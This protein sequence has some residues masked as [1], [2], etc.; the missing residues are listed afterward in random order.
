M[1]APPGDPMMHDDRSGTKQETGHIIAFNRRDG[2]AAA[3]NVEPSAISAADGLAR[4]DIEKFADG[5][6]P[7]EDD[8]RHRMMLNMAVAAAIVLLIAIGLWIADTM[9]VMRK[10]QD[11]V[12]SGRRGC[13]PIELPASR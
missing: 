11:C 5:V 9:A 3:R 7:A 2:P 8:Y 4:T 12:L 13:A 1:I 6:A 10:N